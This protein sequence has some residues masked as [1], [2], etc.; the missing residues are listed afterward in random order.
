MMGFCDAVKAY[1]HVSLKQVKTKMPYTTSTL[2]QD[3]RAA[4]MALYLGHM[5]VIWGCRGS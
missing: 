3:K 1:L 5:R 2:C 4:H